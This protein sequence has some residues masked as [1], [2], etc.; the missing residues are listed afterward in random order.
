MTDA[1]SQATAYSY[2]SFGDMTTANPPGPAIVHNT[3]DLRGRKLTTTDPDMGAWSYSYDA[4][5]SLA[6][7][8]PSSAVERKVS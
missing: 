8:T 1:V 5:G 7:Q 3:Y 4:F 2:D 6:Q